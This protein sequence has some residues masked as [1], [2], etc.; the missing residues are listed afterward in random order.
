MC[1]PAFEDG[2]TVLLVKALL[3]EL[4][5]LLFIELSVETALESFEELQLLS[6]L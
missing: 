2:V 6:L 5:T 1:A 3:W 4:I